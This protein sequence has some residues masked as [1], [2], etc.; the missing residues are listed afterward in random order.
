[1]IKWLVNREVTEGKDMC[2]EASSW[3]EAE[4]GTENVSVGVEGF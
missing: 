1:M 4:A 3:S 2:E